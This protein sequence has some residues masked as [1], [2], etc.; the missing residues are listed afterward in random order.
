MCSI[1]YDDGQSDLKDL[2][3]MQAQEAEKLS[4][5]LTRHRPMIEAFVLRLTRDAG[6]AE[7]ITQMTFLR[8]QT[9]NSAWRGDAAAR[10]WLCS[11][12]L[13]LVR[14]HFRKIQRK[15]EITTEPEVLEQINCPADNAEV[16]FMKKQM[17]DCIA[18]HLQRL[19]QPQYDVVA[20]HDMAGLDHKEIAAQ[21]GITVA[22]SRVI[23][24]R[25]R[26]AFQSILEANCALNLDCG[27]IICEP[28]DTAGYNCERAVN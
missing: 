19:P 6:L 27:D 18:R 21:L 4:E 2:I 3:P 24:H 23:L 16:A 17:S 25:G 22:N 15:P 8:A 7:D 13:N 28:L 20:L 26:A 1:L 14:D 11:I 5:K 10:S 12:A 9:T